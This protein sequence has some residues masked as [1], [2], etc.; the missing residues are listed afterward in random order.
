MCGAGAE[1]TLL[2]VDD[3]IE[4]LTGISLLD[5]TAV[6]ARL[7]VVAAGA[8]GLGFIEYDDTGIEVSG[9]REG[10]NERRGAAVWL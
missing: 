1:R 5:W 10:E 3:R 6:T 9:E 7:V 8:A 2:D 4:T